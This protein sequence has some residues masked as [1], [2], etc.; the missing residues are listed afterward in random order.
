MAVLIL[1]IVALVAF[2]LVL[3]YL[4]DFRFGLHRPDGSELEGQRNFMRGCGPFEM[5][6]GDHAILVLHGIAGSP[7]QMRE[8]CERLSVVKLHGGFRLYGAVLPGHGTDPEDLYG[9]TWQRWYEHVE[10]EYER[11]RE[12]HGRVSVIGFS[13]GAALGL[14][15]AMSHP[16][17][18]LVCM[19]TPCYRHLFHDWLPAHWL[20]R[21]AG[22]FASTARC[23]PKRLPESEDGPEYMIYR[24]MP[25]DALN[26]AVD[27]AR[28][29]R[30]HLAEVKTPTLVVHSSADPASRPRGAQ[31]IYDHL[32]SNEK[33]LVWLEDAPHGLMHGSDEDKAVIHRELV[34]FLSSS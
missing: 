10:A 19:S 15:L 23:F 17:E 4:V 5:G 14:R 27:L 28:E 12:R 16:V 25:M 26:M 34:E 31:Y 11:L 7:A 6:S 2:F 9:I 20:L 24:N 21:I 18:R 29:I 30:P 3:G 32:G 33:R 22:Y 8:M 1:F 13:L